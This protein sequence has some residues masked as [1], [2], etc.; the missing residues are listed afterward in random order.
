VRVE[1][2][3]PEL[4]VHLAAIASPAQAARAPELTY[5]VNFLGTR[6]VLEAAAR[7]AAG[8]RV[9]LVCSADAYG[10]SPPGSPPFSEAAP[11]RPASPYARSKAAGELL[12]GAYAA[13][14]LDVVST[15]S[16]NHSGPGQAEA[17]VLS[18]FA[19]QAVEIAAG[20]REPLLRVGNLDS[21]RDFLDVEDV[22]RAYLALCDPAAPAGVY[23][24]ASGRGVRVGDALDLI[25]RLA[26][27]S[28]AVEADPERHR[29]T[30][31]AVGDASRLRRVTGWE[32]RIALEETLR[33]VVDHWREQ[34]AA[35]S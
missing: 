8:A 30:D 12:G 23:N 4:I 25:L 1:A 32:P 18:S 28:P 7:H 20:L 31:H 10:S 27:V 34:L 5:R 22:V 26:G 15:R 21:V 11:L 2:L 33:R 14:G 9:L 16:F 6:S 19:K 35:S 29:P 17:F 3:R 13:R 24:V